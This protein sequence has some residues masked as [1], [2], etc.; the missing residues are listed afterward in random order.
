[1]LREVRDGSQESVG[2]VTEVTYPHVASVTEQAADSAGLV[3]VIRIRGW[4]LTTDRAEPALRFEQR[5]AL[6][7]SDAERSTQMILALTN[8]S[9]PL[10]A[11]GKSV[12][13]RSIAMPIGVRLD[14]LAS[15]TP[16]VAAG[17]LYALSDA[18]AQPRASLAI[19]ASCPC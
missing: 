8:R 15:R 17:N 13:G 10:A 4:V 1:M 18:L 14:L 19:A 7:D 11:V 16:L 5:F 6:G 9:A 3:V 12:A 2:V